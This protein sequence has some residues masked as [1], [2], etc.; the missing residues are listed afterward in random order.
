MLVPQSL[1]VLGLGIHAGDYAGMGLIYRES[2]VD[3]GYAWKCIG[4]LARQSSAGLGRICM[5]A[6]WQHDWSWL[7]IGSKW[8]LDT[9]V[10]FGLG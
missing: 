9:E 10:P 1:G 5:L 4:K 3:T 7:V 2:P 6:L 8:L